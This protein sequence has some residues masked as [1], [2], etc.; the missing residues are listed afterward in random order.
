MAIEAPIACAIGQPNSEQ[1]VKWLASY[2]C[3]LSFLNFWYGMTTFPNGRSLRLLV[4][5][6]RTS[7][8]TASR[9]GKTYT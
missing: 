7:T 6:W 4:F 3:S 2:T 5:G 1:E 9:L 8:M